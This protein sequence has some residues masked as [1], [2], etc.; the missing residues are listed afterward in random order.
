MHVDPPVMAEDLE[1]MFELKWEH[2]KIWKIIGTE[3][4]IDVD[5]LNSIERD[6]TKD[7]ECL[8]RMINNAKP[9]ITHNTMTKVLRSERI[10]NAVAGT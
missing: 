5:T 7:H 9:Y 2:Y 6:E 8:Y 4:G 3:L 10:T 1:I